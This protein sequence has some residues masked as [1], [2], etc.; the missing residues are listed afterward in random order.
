LPDVLLVDINAFGDERGFFRELFKASVFQAAGVPAR[1]VQDNLS[2]SRR[3]V[4]RGLHYQMDPSAQGKLVTVLKG[5]IYDAAVDIRRGSPTYGQWV[6]VELTDE[7]PQWLYVPP[8]FAHGFCVTSDEA[9]VL[10]KTTAEYAPDTERGV[11][12]NDPAVGVR[13]PV[14]EPVVSPKDAR[15]PGLRDADNNFLYKP[16]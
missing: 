9:D 11:L 13:W 10:Y 8:G 5:R 6:G 2:R 3:G 7:K 15:W 12:W 4:L 1:F 14:A 16:S